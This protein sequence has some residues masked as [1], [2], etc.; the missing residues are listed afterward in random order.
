LTLLLLA[1]WRDFARRNPQPVVKVRSFV[2]KVKENPVVPVAAFGVVLGMVGW[3]TVRHGLR[4]WIRASERWDN[5]ACP[6]CRR[7]LHRVHRAK[8]TKALCWVL[9]MPLSKFRCRNPACGW[10]GMRRTRICVGTLP[11]LAKVGDV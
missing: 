1:D 4:R 5:L 9:G 8:V 2:D 6:R 7:R 10:T 11:G 3:L